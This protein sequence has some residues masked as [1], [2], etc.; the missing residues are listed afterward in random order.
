MSGKAEN[1]QE[2]KNALENKELFSLYFNGFTAS[3][4]SG[5]VL[6][7]LKQQDVPVLILNV[8]HTVAKTL[9]V[10]LGEIMSTFE[11]RTGSIVMT[12]DDL[13][14]KLIESGDDETND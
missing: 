4:G 2:I 10:K 3:I 13:R 14:D 5:D 8:S 7:V 12:T 11:Q 1:I 6:I 9:A